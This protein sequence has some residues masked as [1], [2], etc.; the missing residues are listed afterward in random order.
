MLK[1][2]RISYYLLETAL[3]EGRT[4]SLTTEDLE[5]KKAIKISI[6]H[7][8]LQPIDQII[9]LNIK[10]LWRGS[11]YINPSHRKNLECFMSMRLLLLLLSCFSRV[12]L[13]ANPLMAAHQAPLSLGFSRQE[14]WSGLPF[15]SLM[16]S[17]TLN[18]DKLNYLMFNIIRQWYTDKFISIEGSSETRQCL[19]M[20]VSYWEV[21][22][23]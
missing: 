4:W 22:M 5:I 8:I 1:K 7:N 11:S 16:Q 20:R 21:L 19:W 15:P 12:R 9:L 14:Y 3:I 23:W 6:F 18:R 10:P 13:C 17:R 2:T